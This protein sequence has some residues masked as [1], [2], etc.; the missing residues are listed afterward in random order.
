MPPTYL[1]KAQKVQDSY[2][3]CL[4]SAIFTLYT[5]VKLDA[6]SAAKAKLG[7][8]FKNVKEDV[9]SNSP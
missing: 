6:S 1:N 7:T 4:N 8:L 9:S 3:N 5:I 2:P